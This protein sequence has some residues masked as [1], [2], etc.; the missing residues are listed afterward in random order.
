MTAPPKKVRV[1]YALTYDH[2]DKL[3]RMRRRSWVLGVAL[4]K[5]DKAQEFHINP[6]T[7]RL[8]DELLV[9]AFNNKPSYREAIPNSLDDQ[10]ILVSLN[11][12][13]DDWQFDDPYPKFGYFASLI[14][15]TVFRVFTS[16][17]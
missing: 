1:E 12:T 10:P 13:K 9:A 3:V 16:S 2:N 17:R 11:R 7:T 8:A 5:I 6:V 15:F 4:L 14:T